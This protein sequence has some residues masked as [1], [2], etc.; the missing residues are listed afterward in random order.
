M[1]GRKSRLFGGRFSLWGLRRRRYRAELQISQ[2]D[3][4]RRTAN[5]FHALQEEYK[6]K[7]AP[8]KFVRDGALVLN[9]VDTFQQRHKAAV[10]KTAMFEIPLKQICCGSAPPRG[11]FCGQ[12]LG[13]DEGAM[14]RGFSEIEATIAYPGALTIVISVLWCLHRLKTIYHVAHRYLSRFSRLLLNPRYTELVTSFSHF[15]RTQP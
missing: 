5:C 3:G 4:H 15:L 14:R 13:H 9:H 10:A 8:G 7:S 1:N 11:V 6:G 12:D 2:I